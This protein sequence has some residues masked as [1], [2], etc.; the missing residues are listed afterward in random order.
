MVEDTLTSYLSEYNSKPS[1]SFINFAKK[2]IDD[3]NHTAGIPEFQN[4]KFFKFS[5]NK[6]IYST[7]F[8][9][10]MVVFKIDRKKTYINRI[11]KNDGEDHKI[12][13]LTWSGNELNIKK[14]KKFTDKFNFISLRKI[15]K[16]TKKLKNTKILKEFFS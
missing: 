2:I 5:L 3:V 9:E 1:F 7:H 15:T 10:S 13:D 6:Y 12:K 4:K 8:Y 16:I 11:I 14:F